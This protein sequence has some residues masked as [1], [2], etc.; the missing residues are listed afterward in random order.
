MNWK[1]SIIAVLQNS[2]EPMHYA[3]IAQEVAKRKYRRRNELG[4]TPANT[5]AVTIG[6]SINNEGNFSPF[7]RSTRGYYALRVKKSKSKLMEENPSA[8]ISPTTGI[9]NALGMFWE[10]SKVI[11][12][13]DPKILGRQQQD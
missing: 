2:E 10:R 1:D 12:K 7:V 6:N 8:A 13:T 3:D 5:V 9:I 4:A 11:W